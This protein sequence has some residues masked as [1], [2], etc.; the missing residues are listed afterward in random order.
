MPHL[1]RRP[2]KDPGAPNP[3]LAEVFAIAAFGQ[4][5][6][7]ELVALRKPDLAMPIRRRPTAD[8]IAGG[9]PPDKLIDDGTPILHISHALAE[10]NSGAATADGTEVQRWQAQS[11]ATRGDPPRDPGAA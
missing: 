11:G 3:S 5:R 8:E 10:L 4:L 1:G 2:D 7:G 9:A 6:F